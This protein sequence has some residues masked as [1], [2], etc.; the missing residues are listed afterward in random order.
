MVAVTP[1]G[2]FELIFQAV[3]LIGVFAF[4]WQ[5]LISPIFRLLHRLGSVVM[6]PLRPLEKYAEPEHRDPTRPRSWED[7]AAYVYVAE[8]MRQ[9]D[10]KQLPPKT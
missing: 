9:F 8:R 10:R 4:F 1:V 7:Q 3:L 6:L 2:P 5:E